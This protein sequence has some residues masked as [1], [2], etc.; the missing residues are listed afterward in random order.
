[1][2]VEVDKMLVEREMKY[3]CRF[4][5]AIE[6]FRQQCGGRDERVE[7]REGFCIRPG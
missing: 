6:G 1:M 5:A 3:G 4:G 2:A 7:D